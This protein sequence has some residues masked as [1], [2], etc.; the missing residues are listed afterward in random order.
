MCVYVCENCRP[1]MSY[2]L[3]GLQ[4]QIPLEQKRH[5]SASASVFQDVG[6]VTTRQTWYSTWVLCIV[7]NTGDQVLKIS[8]S[9]LILCL[10][11]SFGLFVQI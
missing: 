1:F 7:I 10:F 8:Y 3:S 5:P 2:V 6:H 11:Q 9:N 4:S